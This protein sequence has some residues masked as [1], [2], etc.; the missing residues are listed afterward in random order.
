MMANAGM[1]NFYIFISFKF[2]D[3]VLS[4]VLYALIIFCK[5]SKIN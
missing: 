2:V 4:N 1:F 5:R 3:T